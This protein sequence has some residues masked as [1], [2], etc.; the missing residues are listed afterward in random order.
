M[1]D[2]ISEARREWSKAQILIQSPPW[3]G[4]PKSAHLVKLLSEEEPTIE[5]E[6]WAMVF[7]S[8]NLLSAY[9]MYTLFKRHSVKLA[10]LP[11][12]LKG[13]SGK[14]TVHLGSFRI[15]QTYQDFVEEMIKYGKIF[16]EPHN[17]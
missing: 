4:E 8:D 5:D 6:L 7:D 3:E 9:S 13:R 16:T 15:K 11:D 2:L 1:H 12:Q 10:N 17:D 14:I